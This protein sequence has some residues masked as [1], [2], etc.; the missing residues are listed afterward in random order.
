MHITVQGISGY[1]YRVTM[2]EHD[3]IVD[4]PREEG[5]DDRGPTP[6]DLFVAGLASC[7]AYYAGKFLARRGRKW[8]RRVG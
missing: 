1:S 7:A 6:T 5:G 8:T 3:V 2:G 4:Q